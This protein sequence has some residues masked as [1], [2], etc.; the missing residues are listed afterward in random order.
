MRRVYNHAVG[1]DQAGKPMTPTELK[2]AE[3]FLRKALPDL[4]RTE[5]ANKE[6]EELRIILQHAIASPPNADN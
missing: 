6:G 4:A 2:A 1:E 5:L 3:L